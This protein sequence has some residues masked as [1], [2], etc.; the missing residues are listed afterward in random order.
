MVSQ[1][2]TMIVNVNFILCCRYEQV[3]ADEHI[4]QCLQAVMDLELE[5]DLELL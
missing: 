2:F 5:N 4:A 3:D 1:Y